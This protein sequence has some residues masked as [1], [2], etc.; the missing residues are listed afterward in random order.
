MIGV[1][2]AWYNLMICVSKLTCVREERELS[3]NS[4]WKTQKICT[5]ARLSGTKGV[6]ENTITRGGSKSRVLRG[7]QG[8]NVKG[9]FREVGKYLGNFANDWSLVAKSTKEFQ[10]LE[11]EVDGDKK[12]SGGNGY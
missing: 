9:T 5:A 3:K 8:R 2:L 6:T 1:V 10:E 7:N 12:G 4:I 11:E